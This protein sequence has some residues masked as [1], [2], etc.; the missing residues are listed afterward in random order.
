[1]VLLTIRLCVAA[2][3]KHVSSEEIMQAA[4]DLKV[5][6]Q[7]ADGL[8]EDAIRYCKSTKSAY[9][10]KDLEESISENLAQGNSRLPGTISA[11]HIWR[12]AKVAGLI[13]FMLATDLM[14]CNVDFDDP[15]ARKVAQRG[16]GI[17]SAFENAKSAFQTLALQQTIWQEEQQETLKEQ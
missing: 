13:Q 1:M 6:T 16:L 9:T 11:S 10:T 4:F 5:A 12:V 14:A 3:N 7:D 17:Y 8:N 15:R 2:Q